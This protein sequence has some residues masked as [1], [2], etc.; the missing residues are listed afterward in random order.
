M[1]KTTMLICTFLL[2][3]IFLV[4]CGDN[5]TNQRETKGETA[6]ENKAHNEMM[7]NMKMAHDGRIS[8]DLSPQMAQHQLMNMRNH[9]AAVK[10]VINFLSKDEFDSASEVAHSGL[11]LTKQME[12]MCTS[13]NN[14]EFVKLGLEFHRSADSL[15]D[16]L[17]TKDKNKSL[18]ALSTTMNFCVVCHSTFRQ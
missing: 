7:G 4:S 8:L 12:K 5:K 13:F 14:P 2:T 6:T 9:V 17:K 10:S 11:G 18:Q 1:K 16:V 3:G 15:A